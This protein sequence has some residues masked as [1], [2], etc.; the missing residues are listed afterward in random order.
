MK[1]LNKKL[2]CFSVIIALVFSCQVMLPQTKADKIETLLNQYHKF[3]E[4]NGSALVAEGGEIIYKNGFGMANM[5]WNIPNTPETKFRLG[6]I[7]KQFTAMLIMQLVEDGKLKLD[8][9]IS[10]Y[11]PDYPKEKGEKIT[12]HYLLTHTSGIPNYTDLPSFG[13][14]MRDPLKPIDLIKTFWDLPLD[15]EPGARFNY[16]NSGYI[17]LGYIIEEVSGKTYEDELKEKIF[18]P[19]NMKNS[20]YDHAADIITNRASGYNK[21]GTNYYNA[22]YIDMSIPYAAGSIYS[23]VEDLYL[24]DQALYANKILS[25]KY[26]EEIF[27]PYSKPPFADGYGYGWGL[28]K[29]H[30]DN[31][32][33]SLTI[34]SHGGAINGFNSIIVRIKNNKDLIVLLNNTGG[35]NLTEM[36]N[37]MIN[38]LYNQQYEL[39][40][41]PLI[42][43]FDEFLNAN[44]IDEASTFYNKKIEEGEKIPEAQMNILGYGYLNK[45]EYKTAAGIF[46]LNVNAYPESYN[47]YDSYGEALMAAG[48]KDDAIANYK[49]SIELNPKNINGI[50]K[51]KELGINIAPLEDAHVDPNVYKILTGKYE[52]NPQFAI[53]VT[54]EDDKLYAQ[55]T[56]QPRIELFPISELKYYTKVVDAQITF[57]KGDDGKIEKLFLRQNGENMHGNKVE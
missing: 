40:K 5:E 30:L 29:M 44:G 51:L 8:I 2:F 34:I 32:E 28:S 24:W 33:D 9:P 16:S 36:S 41:K 38:I 18:E 27:T 31:T 13:K 55:G 48:D 50:E 35:T 37:K 43:S 12:I 23:T 54:E 57:V 39:P 53:V 22:A 19:L 21:S 42:L 26:M 47:V 14:I 4:F 7:T 25:E 20:G 52:L 46:K 11:I 56:G 6:S 1:Y 10:A 45:K 17:V 15:F 49:K 3:Q